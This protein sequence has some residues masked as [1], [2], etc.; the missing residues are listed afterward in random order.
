MR[1]EADAVDWSA[2]VLASQVLFRCCT[3]NGHYVNFPIGFLTVLFYLNEAL[4]SLGSGKE[5][6][7]KDL[8]AILQREP[9]LPAI[10]GWFN[11]HYS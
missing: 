10:E 11:T 8:G 9:T 4:P 1:S 3:S 6:A 7:I 5:Q 2:K